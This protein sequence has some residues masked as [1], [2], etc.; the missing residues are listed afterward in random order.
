MKKIIYL[1]L[2]LSSPVFAQLSINSDISILQAQADEGNPEAKF[3]LGALYYSGSGVDQSF[4]KAFE[5]FE[6]ASK[7]GWVSAT[8]N[9]GVIYSKGRGTDVD[10]TKA[11]SYYKKA[12]LGG[13]DRAQYVYASWL[14]DGKEIETNPLESMEWFKRAAVQNYGPALIEVARGYENGLSG[15]RD[16]RE[17]VKLYRQARSHDDGSDNLTFY[18]ATY[19]LGVLYL[20]GLGVQQNKRKGLKFIKDAAGNG[21][22]EAKKELAKVSQE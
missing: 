13:L 4:E 1:L 14:R 17:A 2:F 18:T 11:L 3:F 9:L 6:E 8:Y 16:Y 5:L 21:I 15:R 12:A 22:Q 7:A 20:K 19:R 10:T